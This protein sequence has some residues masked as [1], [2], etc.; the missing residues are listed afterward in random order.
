[1]KHFLTWLVLCSGIVLPRT[2]SA[3]DVVLGASEVFISAAGVPVVSSGV[4]P[5]VV[6][7]AVSVFPQVQVL[8]FA[9]RIV[10]SPC[11]AT[12]RLSFQRTVFIERRAVI[13]PRP[14]VLRRPRVRTRSVT[15]VR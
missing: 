3:C 15:V 4:V 8:S 5:L 14:R 1:M 12:R 7:P 10:A 6:T 2:A 11:F 13:A 9:P